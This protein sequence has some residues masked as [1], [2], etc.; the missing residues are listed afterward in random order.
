MKILTQKIE[1]TSNLQLSGRELELLD[2]FLAYDNKARIAEI[3]PNS[4]QG[5]VSVKEMTEFISGL[6]SSVNHMIHN[7]N[8][9]A[10]QGL[11]RG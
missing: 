1:V 9:T 2:N 4:Y 5:G 8:E 3:C 10:K 7:I 6:K 11:V